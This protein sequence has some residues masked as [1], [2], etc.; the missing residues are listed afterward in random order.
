V[1]VV[2][3]MM[4]IR[5]REGIAMAMVVNSGVGMEETTR[6]QTKEET[7]QRERNGTW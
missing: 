1:V 2:T 5:T 4:T 6:D 3:M 7:K